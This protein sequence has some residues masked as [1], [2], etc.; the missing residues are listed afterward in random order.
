MGFGAFCV[1]VL[2]GGGGCYGASKVSSG[3]YL[4]LAL[5]LPGSFCRLL[6]G[7]YVLFII[8]FP[9]SLRAPTVDGINPAVP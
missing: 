9:Q 3:V 8:E 1:S 2:F 6:T 7:P 5:V 4:A